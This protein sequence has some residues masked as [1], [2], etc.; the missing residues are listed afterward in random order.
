MSMMQPPPSDEFNVVEELSSS[1][2]KAQT[3][4]RSSSS[5]FLSE[6]DGEPLFVK[7]DFTVRGGALG[8]RSNMFKVSTAQSPYLKK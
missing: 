2:G 8:R 1:R 6:D 3:E 4:F 5:S 7:K